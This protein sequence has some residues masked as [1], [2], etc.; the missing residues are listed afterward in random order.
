VKGLLQIARLDSI[1]FLADSE[2]QA[3]AQ[4]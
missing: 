1:F 4:K 2:Q 3:L